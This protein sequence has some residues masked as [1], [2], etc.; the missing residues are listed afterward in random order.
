M[1]ILSFSTCFPSSVDPDRGIFVYNRLAALAKLAQ[2]EVVH[3]VGKFLWHD[4][5]AVPK[6]ASEQFGKLTVYHPRFFYIP[7]VLKHLDAGFY[8]Q[9][10]RPWLKKHIDRHGRP[11]VMDVHF[12]WPEA[13]GCGLLA[14]QFNLPYTVTLRGVINSRIKNPIMRPLI[15]EALQQADAVISVSDEMAE[16]A[17]SH[18]V[19]REKCTVIPNGVTLDAFYPIPRKQA[20]AALKLDPARRYIVCV[21]GIRPSKGLTELVEATARLGEDVHTLIVGEVGSAR[22]Y[23][24]QLAAL[25]EKLGCSSRFTL[26]GAQPHEKVPIYLNA[27]SVS[28]LASHVE[29]CP[30]AVLEAL[31][32]GVPVVATSVGQIG[33]MIEPGRNGLIVPVGD[34]AALARAIGEALGREWSAQEISHSPAVVSWDDVARHVMAVMQ[35]VTEAKR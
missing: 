29:G 5:F 25:A 18:G 7:G 32:C 27:A 33:K 6:A 8:A 24:G 4:A 13:V 35:K 17:I 10:L 9:S 28:V 14:R 16:L 12:E 1:R 31:G 23:A 2:L 11:D 22:E 3:P 26:V 19:P 21:A 15:V 20:L 30:N 34:S